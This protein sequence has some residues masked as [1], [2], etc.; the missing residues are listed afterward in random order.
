MHTR[1][2][3]ANG[4]SLKYFPETGLP[5]YFLADTTADSGTVRVRVGLIGSGGGGTAGNILTNDPD[6]SNAKVYRINEIQKELKQRL[7]K[8]VKPEKS[9]N[10][11]TTN[12]NTSED[13]NC[14][15]FEITWET[16][17]DVQIYVGDECENIPTEHPDITYVLSPVNQYYKVLLEEDDSPDSWAWSMIDVCDTPDPKQTGGS[18]P[19]NYRRYRYDGNDF[20]NTWEIKPYKDNENDIHYFFVYPGTNQPAPLFFD[21]AIGTCDYKMLL[22]GFPDGYTKLYSVSDVDDDAKI[23]NSDA[24]RAFY[25][26]CGFLC[27]PTRVNKYQLI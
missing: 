8:E 14:P 21:F 7:S 3:I 23:K 24:D 26:F 27:Y 5:I 22:D 13:A 1:N 17:K 4:D 18:K 2:L 9:L 16:Q 20:V 6:S 25:D 15:I 19:A 11:N 10:K 12:L